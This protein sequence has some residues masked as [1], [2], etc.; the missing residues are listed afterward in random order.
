MCYECKESCHYKS[1][2]LNLQKEKPKKKFSK[3]KKK[4]LMAIWDDSESSEVRTESED[5]RANIALMANISDD[6]RSSESVS[7]SGKR[8]IL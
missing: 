1:D 7:E 4:S 5:E 8:G 6:T 3:E 2:C